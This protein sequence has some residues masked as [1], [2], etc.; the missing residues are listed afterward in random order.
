MLDNLSPEEIDNLYTQFDL[1]MA[2]YSEDFGSLMK[3]RGFSSSKRQFSRKEIVGSL[4]LFYGDSPV[5]LLLYFYV[6]NENSLR[7]WIISANGIRG[8]HTQKL[9]PNTLVE[10]EQR[11][12]TD[13]KLKIKTVGRVA[14]KRVQNTDTDDAQSIERK[15]NPSKDYIFKREGENPIRGISNILF[16]SSL[17]DTLIEDQIEH[18]I[19]LPALNIQ[20]IPI[21]ILTPFENGKCLLEI[22]SYSITPYLT[23]VEKLNGR[24]SKH[25]LQNFEK[26]TLAEHS[27]LVG[28][29]AFPENAVWDLPPLPGAEEE[30]M[31]LSEA[32]ALSSNKLLIGEKAEK[33]RILEEVGKA[34]LLYFATHGVAD[35]SN[36]LEGGGLFFAPDENDPEGFWS[37]IEIQET[38]LSAFLVVLSAC[39]TG[40]GAPQDAGVIGV[41][42]AFHIAGAENIIMSLWSVDDQA[43]QELMQIFMEEIQKPQKYFP[44]GHLRKAMLTY[45][46][47]RPDPIY[48]AAFANFGTPY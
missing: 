32:V 14:T 41:S 44:A 7:T 22:W 18:L 19:I 45:K 38:T 20:Q 28:N 2:D 17:V 37:C 40:L 24:T 21:A 11:L 36:P 12:K 15:A 42:R 48:W 33:G 27:L 43:T 10:L 25:G 3:V 1:D 47:K 34:V 5:V 13:L 29:P 16:P 35:A 6:E 8:V 4:Q 23:L 30:V 46:E 31:K 9:N 39:Q 26:E